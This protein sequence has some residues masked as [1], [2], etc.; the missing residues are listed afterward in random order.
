MN[1]IVLIAESEGF[2]R[3]DMQQF[4]QLIGHSVSFYGDVVKD[5]THVVEVDKAAEEFI[6]KAVAGIEKRGRRI[7][8]AKKHLVTVAGKKR[9]ITAQK[10]GKWWSARCGGES[11]NGWFSEERAVN[12]M[13][14]LLDVR[15]N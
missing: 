12:V 11:T 1:D 8:A 3:E 13:K 10:F 5:R 4:Y 14:A 2:S 6:D 7:S 9:V 15:L